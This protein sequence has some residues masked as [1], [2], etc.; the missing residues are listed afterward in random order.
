MAETLPNHDDIVSRPH[1]RWDLP[2][3]APIEPPGP[4]VRPRTPR[5][6]IVKRV[7]WG[8]LATFVILFAYLALTAPLSK[9]LKPMAPPTIV[10]L[11]ADGTPIAR[12]GAVI[13]RPVEAALLPDNVK[14]ALIAIEDRRFRSHWGIDPRG[15]ARATWNNLRGNSTQGG[16]TI[17][18]QLAKMTFLSPDRKITRKAREALIAFWLEAWLT[19]DQILERY[20]SN[21]YY[22]DNVYG[23]RAASLHYFSRQP[24]NLSL[25]QAAMLAGVV[26]APTRLSP[27]R[28][29]ARAQK[30]ERMVLN[31]MAQSGYI[32]Q[33]QADATPAAVLH[34]MPAPKT[35]SGTYFADWAAGQARAATEDAYG[36]SEIRTTLDPNL[37]KAANAVIGR[38]GLGEAQAAI[39]AMRPNG[40][41]VAMV[42]GKSY[43]TSPFN[44]AT[45]A[46]RQPG[47]AFKLFVYLAA[48]RSG[49][50]PETMVDDSAI[51]EGKY[52]PKN[53]G[54]SY[55]GQ[56]S[57]ER[58]FA[59]S[60]NV[61]AVRLYR[62]L[63]GAAVIQAARD[64]GIKS[65]LVDDPTLALGSSGVT[66]LELTSA[67]AALAADHYPVVP[68]GLPADEPGLLD[69][70]MAMRHTFDPR[71]RKDMLTL[72]HRVVTSGTG[73]SANLAIETFGK[74]G[75][76]QDNRDAW[77]VGFAGDLIVGVWIGRDD[78]KPLGGLHGGGLPA[79][80]WRDFMSQ[81]IP[82]SRLPTPVA[83]ETVPE[84]PE[85]ALNVTLGNGALVE[86]D[87]ER[88]VDLNT[89]LGTIRLNGD[90][91]EAR[92]REEGPPPDESQPPQ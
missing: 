24:E 36:E 76:S 84:E 71:V 80:I 87:P 64:L 88:G 57:L 30:R 60:S 50:T 20:L 11:A 63:G 51:V 32:T 47:S 89:D 58:A 54:A 4:P 37:Q 39:V 18:Q 12:K 42:G 49:M 25:T 14:N 52:R 78:N 35:P 92:R 1:G 82:G 34:V 72:L 83:D 91:I 74:T 9:S 86:I 26:Q 85:A 59:K 81:A 22:G 48:L 5:R 43:K 2:P 41:V 8:M 40:E 44:R 3:V 56:I 75:T 10:L 6:I 61:A 29:L 45:Q 31:A 46:R 23:L 69:R 55:R 21:T 79:Q 13:D 66:L 15:M 17:T 27:T 7:L 62:Q 33:A 65:P 70:L 77:F 90:G 28:N 67:Y 68:R 19:K 73:Q 16:S 38:A 53:D